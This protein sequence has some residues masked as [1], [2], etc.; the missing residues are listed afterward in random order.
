M[1]SVKK[2]RVTSVSDFKR[3]LASLNVE[4]PVLVTQ[5]GD[6]LYVVQD[7]V[8]YELQQEQMALL[9]LLAIAEKDVNAGRVVGQADLLGGLQHRALAYA[10]PHDKP[11][12]ED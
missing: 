9:K 8:Q 4:E 3:G 2:P 5:N 7:P 12:H 6:P 10:K 1:Y 11:Q